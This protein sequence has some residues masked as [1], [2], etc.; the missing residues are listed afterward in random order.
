MPLNFTTKQINKSSTIDS[1][2]RFNPQAVAAGDLN[3]DGKL[4]IVTNGVAVFL[5]D[6]IGNFTAVGLPAFANDS[7]IV[8]GFINSYAADLVVADLNRDGNPDVVSV[9]DQ[10]ITALLG[11]GTGSF[12]SAQISVTEIEPRSIAL[13]DFNGDGNLDALTLH[14]NYYP[15]DRVIQ[16]V[17]L[18]LGD[19]KDSFSSPTSIPIP[20]ATACKIEDVTV[21]DFNG[22]GQT[23]VAVISNVEVQR[24]RISVSQNQVT[25]L[26]GN[27]AGQF[28]SVDQFNLDQGG[29]NRLTA[30]DLNGDGKDDLA[31]AGNKLNILLGS[32]SG[33]LKPQ[34]RESISTIDSLTSRDFNG[35]GTLDLVTTTGDAGVIY[36]NVFLGDG[37]GNFS[38]FSQSFSAFVSYDRSDESNGYDVVTGDF[39]GD[40]KLDF[41]TA[42]GRSYTQGTVTVFL[43]STTSSEALVVDEFG[44]D[45]SM[46]SKGAITVDLAKRTLRLT[47]Q[48]EFRTQLNRFVTDVIGTRRN[49]TIRGNNFNFNNRSNFLNGYGGDDVILGLGGN[50]RII[51]GA[52]DDKLTG[53]DGRDRF[54][55]SSTPNY[56][57]GLNQPFRRSRLGVDQLEDFQTG[58]DKIVL[59]RGTFTA[60]G[61]NISFA[62][63]DD[64]TEAATSN[65][66]LTYIRS[67]GK[68]YYNENGS[69]AG[70][71]T[72]GLFAVLINNAALSEKDFSAFI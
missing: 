12:S 42:D 72:G 14:S 23:D 64:S 17:L 4:D 7:S 45:A 52:G 65:A 48:P 24:K 31:V 60:L 56:P 34:H 37:R 68:L 28:R 3:R 57:D 32:S 35:D 66:I 11:D 8:N 26:L 29:V 58:R 6:G 43:N 59:D 44:V 39:N 53:G 36:A 51:G 46:V 41:A 61:R 67:S 25:V 30:A 50:D 21:A 13:E 9:S 19:G 54:I 15:Y 16:T 20:I 2:N 5:G 33:K 71:G 18:H 27:G 49:D 63:V 47:A 22:D 69:R 62:S 10:K 38:N 70:L 1:P 40:G 55:F